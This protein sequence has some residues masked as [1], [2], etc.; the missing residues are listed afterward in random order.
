MN[1]NCMKFILVEKIVLSGG[2]LVIIL[3]RQFTYISWGNHSAIIQHVARILNSKFQGLGNK[4][5]QTKNFSKYY[6]FNNII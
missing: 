2:F 5:N 4:C 3:E 6:S 1:P